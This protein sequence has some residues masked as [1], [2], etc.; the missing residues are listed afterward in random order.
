VKTLATLGALVAA[1]IAGVLFLWPASEGPEPIAY[2][3]DV[4]A[5]CRMHLGRPGFAGELREAGGALRK[6]DDIGC[7]LRGIVETHAEASAA[8]VEDHAGGGFVALPTAHLVR[9]AAAGTPMGYGLVAFREDDAARAYSEA[10]HGSVVPL[11]LALR[12]VSP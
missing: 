5:H 10:H 2:G 1:V 7:L 4:C 6:F 12:E 11:E 9:A 8:W 3:R